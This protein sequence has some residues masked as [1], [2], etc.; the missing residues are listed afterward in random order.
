MDASSFDV[1]IYGATPAGIAAAVR[2]ARGG[3]TAA[4]IHWHRHLGGMLSSGLGIYDTSYFGN[5]CPLVEEIFA[6]ILRHYAERYGRDSDQ[7]RLCA[8]N[9]TFEPHVAERVLT[10]MVAAERK[11]EVIGGW[12]VDAVERNGRMINAVHL[13]PF[14][15]EGR[16]TV[17]GAVF[18]DTS[19]EGDLAAAAGAPYRIGRE[20]RAEYGEPHA[21]RIFTRY[22]ERSAESEMFPFAAAKGLINLRPFDLCSGR[23]FPGSTGEGD[24]A[25][26]S[27]NYRI[28]LSRDPA[29]QVPVERPENY[30]RENYA[31]LLQDEIESL[32]TPYPVKS[33]WLV[34]DIRNFRFRNHREIPNCKISWNHGQ[35]PG[36]NHRYPDAGWPERLRILAEHRDH[37][38]GLL[39]FLQNDPEVPA[40][41]RAR[42]RELGLACDE[43]TDNGHIPWEIYVREARRIEGRAVFTEFDAS[44][45]PGIDRAPVHAD[46]VAITDWMMD[47]HECTTDR[48][49]GSAYEGAVLL[50]ELTRPGQ[51]PYRCLLPQGLDNLLVPVCLSASH[52]GWGTIRVEPTWIH[53]AESAAH[54]CLLSLERGQPP[55]GL[56][57]SALQRRLVESGVMIS[58]FNDCDMAHRGRFVPA[59]QFFGAK[60]FFSSYDAKPADP[61]DA[62]TARVW[63]H[64]FCALVTG[65]L[66]ALELA[67]RVAQCGAVPRTPIAPA[68]F[69]ALF[70]QQIAFALGVRPEALPIAP[71][72]GNPPEAALTRAEACERM[73]AAHS[74]LGGAR[75]DGRPAA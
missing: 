73:Y 36:R 20:P 59:V 58:F 75:A 10:G 17:S 2:C 55:A 67:K 18:L 11:I 50:S 26:M 46:S 32:G 12:T 39:W 4:L 8:R 7:A 40:E 13:R 29:N 33:A 56:D 41:V 44:L 61:L 27:Y 45:A 64:G 65:R 5:R 69:H 37:E 63:I 66:D 14:A 57:V 34:D 3:R 25:V 68:E 38:L 52:V 53:L 19:Y 42:A 31:G 16:R 1:V 71:M 51:V 24:G 22:E 43:F 70:V 49:P 60:G 48:M 6:G 72:D 74:A 9:R 15:G 47:S 35:F 30:R 23:I 21:G 54:A 28:F 62:A